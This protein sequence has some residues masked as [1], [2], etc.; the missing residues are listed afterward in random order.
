MW[1]VAPQPRPVQTRENRWCS[2]PHRPC[3]HLTR[4]GHPREL[5]KCRECANA[6]IPGGGSHLGIQTTRGPKAEFSPCR[7]G[8]KSSKQNCRKCKL[9]GLPGGGTR[10]CAAHNKRLSRCTECGPD[11]VAC[12]QTEVP[13]AARP[14]ETALQNGTP[15]CAQTEVPLAAR[16]LETA[17]QNGTPAPAA[18]ADGSAPLE[19]RAAKPVSRRLQLVSGCEASAARIKLNEVG[20]AH[21]GSLSPAADCAILPTCSVTPSTSVRKRQASTDTPMSL[22]VRCRVKGLCKETLPDEAQ[23]QAAI[24]KQ[25]RT[26][27]MNVVP[28]KDVQAA[29]QENLPNRHTL[30][31]AEDAQQQKKGSILSPCSE[32]KKQDMRLA[33]ASR[34][35]KEEEKRKEKRARELDKD[36]TRKKLEQNARTDAFR[37]DKRFRGDSRPT[38]NKNGGGFLNTKNMPWSIQNHDASVNCLGHDAPAGFSVRAQKNLM[39]ARQTLPHVP[40]TQQPTPA[41]LARSRLNTQVPSPVELNDDKQSGST[42]SRGA[43]VKLSTSVASTDTAMSLD[44]TCLVKRLCKEILPDEAQG[45]EHTNFQNVYNRMW[46]ILNSLPWHKDVDMAA[47]SENGMR[48]DVHGLTKTMLTAVEREAASRAAAPIVVDGCTEFYERLPPSLLTNAGAPFSVKTAPS[49]ELVLCS[50]EC[51]QATVS[52]VTPP[53]VVVCSNLTS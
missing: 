5:R 48:E 15:R 43:S 25:A 30:H 50:T 37:W 38:F 7:H 52:G 8:S 26:P 22:D 40:A 36:T 18:F 24:R 14:L 31:R 35:K 44:V 3:K 2:G 1:Q 32:Q 16:P 45:Q 46:P 10:L 47:I 13:L 20:G 28:S 39:L 34:T 9:E 19:V 51:Q 33:C 49:R 6:K 23:R 12:A 53:R 17:L 41:L 42:R 29:A 11:K 21:D 27:H 4:F